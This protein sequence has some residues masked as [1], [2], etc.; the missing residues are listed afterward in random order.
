MSWDQ[1]LLTQIKQEVDLD[2]F[3]KS[4]DNKTTEE[5]K[6]NKETD[7]D[8]CNDFH[9]SFN[10][11]LVEDLDTNEQVYGFLDLKKKLFRFY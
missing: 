8:E 3:L 1:N 6:V 11:A 7:Y 2:S 9:E 5:E 4:N 10:S